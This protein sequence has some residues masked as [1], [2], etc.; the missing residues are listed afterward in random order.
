M[1]TSGLNRWLL[2]DDPVPDDFIADSVILDDRPVAPKQLDRKGVAVFDRDV[3]DVQ[4]M[5]AL[6]F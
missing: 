5:I 6:R 4:K 2:A 1:E 3:V